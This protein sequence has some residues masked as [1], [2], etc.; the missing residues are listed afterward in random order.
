MSNIAETN[1]GGLRPIGKIWGFFRWSLIGFAVLSALMVPSLL[2]MQLF[3]H[4][5]FVRGEQGANLGTEGMIIDLH[6]GAI[7]ILYIVFFIACV[8]GYARFFQRSMHNARQL[9]PDAD[10]I[11]PM[12]MWLWNIVPIAALWMPFKG[13][14]QVWG[15]L[16]TNAGEE[17]RYPAS[18]GWWWGLWIVSNI[19]SNIT[20]RL[21][22]G[23]F[24]FQLDASNYQDLMFVQWID[25]V[26]SGL[27]AIS[28]FALL[29]IAT[30]IARLQQDFSLN[31][32]SALKEVF[33]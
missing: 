23:A 14:R 11:A 33:E 18:F 7:G 9:E 27:S 2:H 26:T 22:G 20:W 15:I 13:V 3:L 4:R 17:V 30:K 16:K 31:S 25:I 1:T 10:T 21:P 28:A 19:I 29:S 12:G 8:I 24:D 5:I 32:Q 6:M